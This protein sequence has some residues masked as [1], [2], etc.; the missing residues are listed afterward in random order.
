MHMPPLRGSS[1]L[2][3][4]T[5]LKAFKRAPEARQMFSLGREPQEKRTKK[6]S[7]RGAAADIASGVSTHRRQRKVSEAGDRRPTNRPVVQNG[8]CPLVRWRLQDAQRRRRI[9]GI[10]R[11]GAKTQSRREEQKPRAPRGIRPAETQY[12]VLLSN[13]IIFTARYGHTLLD[14]SEG[15]VRTQKNP[16]RLCASASLC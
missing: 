3:S 12:K 14:R 8:H 1:H 13:P 6:M 5:V 2:G 10:E 7:S 11:R 15:C 4:R 16:L 9:P